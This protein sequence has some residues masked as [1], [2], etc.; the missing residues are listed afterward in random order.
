MWVWRIYS[1]LAWCIGVI[2]GFDFV[3]LTIFC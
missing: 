3:H 2:D 1:Y